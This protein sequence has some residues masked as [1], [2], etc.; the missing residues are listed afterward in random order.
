MKWS[1]A[2][3]WNRLRAVR[4]VGAGHRMREGEQIEP[5]HTGSSVVTPAGKGGGGGWTKVG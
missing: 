5:T 1:E 4:G 2:L 3:S